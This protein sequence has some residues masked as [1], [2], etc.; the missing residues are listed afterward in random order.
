MKNF[1]NPLKGGSFLEQLLITGLI[2]F[3]LI[4]GFNGLMN[5]SSKTTELPISEVARLVQAGEVK[6]ITV[7]GSQVEVLNS[8]DEKIITQKDNAAPLE[9]T[10][11]Q[12]GVT[13]EMLQK[14]NIAVDNKTFSSFL[15]SFLPIL[16]PALLF[17]FIGLFL[18]KSL[19]GAGVQ[20]MSFGQSKAK[21]IDP[22]DESQKITFKDVA[23]AKEAKQELGEIVDFLKNPQKFIEIGAVIPKGVLMMGAPGTGKTMLARA[24]AGEAAVPFFHLSGSEFIEMFVGVGASRVRDLFTMAKKASPAIV[25]IDE[26]DAIGRVRGTGLGGGND[27][28][29]QTLNQILVEMDG[30]EKNEKVIVMAATNRPDVLDPALVRPGRFDRR[31]TLDLPD[32]NDREA[33]LEVQSRTKPKDESVNLRVIAERTPGFSGADLYSLMNEAALFAARHDRKKI[34]Q[35]DIIDSI[36]KVILGPERRSHLKSKK[37]TELTAYHEAGHALV[38]AVLPNADPV[39][40]VSIISRGSAG[41][42]TLSL[43]N[44]EQKMHSKLSFLDEIAMT[45]GG[46][47]VEE[48]VYGTVTTGPSSDLQSATAKAKNMVTKYGMSDKVGPRAIESAPTVTKK[49]SFGN[50]EDVHSEELRAVV[51]NEI[52]RIVREQ[53]EVARKVIRDYRPALDK[54]ASELLKKENLERDDFEVILKEFNIPLKSGEGVVVTD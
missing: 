35:L 9:E 17:I 20:A 23:G 33:I 5:W 16:I 13:A 38:G 6:K 24:V 3:V 12:Y 22:K 1:K 25:F 51:D 28:R 29:E 7:Y 30:F 48:M 19:K 4:T 44:D 14:V 49:Y 42:Y 32:K 8:K 53:L 45:L 18:A 10:L 11:S 40:K 26:I 36:E 52:E 46:Y 21:I 34:S 37:E 43:P 50:E 31:V 39:H 15:F 54:M 47:A 2:F 41:G 27:E